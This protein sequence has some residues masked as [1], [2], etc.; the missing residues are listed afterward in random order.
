[1]KASIGLPGGFPAGPAGRGG[2]STGRNAQ[3]ACHSA[4]AAIHCFR[5]S[6][7]AAVSRGPSGGIWR[8][9]S[10]EVIRAII[11]LVATSPG[12]TAVAPLSSA[13]VAAARSSSRNPASLVSGPWQ[14]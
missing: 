3:W 2:R 9:W 13:P 11:S 5:A 6:T 14:A 10:V 8:S 4:P 7:S 12:T 1:M